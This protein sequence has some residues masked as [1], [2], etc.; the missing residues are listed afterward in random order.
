MRQRVHVGRR[1]KL[2]GKR[3]FRHAT[4]RLGLPDDIPPA[5]VSFQVCGIFRRGGIGDLRPLLEPDACM[6]VVAL[7]GSQ[8]DGLPHVGEQSLVNADPVAEIAC[9]TQVGE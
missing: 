8:R 5:F 3:G 7:P 4:G 9:H 2:G 1:A 6:H